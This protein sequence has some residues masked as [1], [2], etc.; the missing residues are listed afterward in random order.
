MERDP[1]RAARNRASEGFVIRQRERRAPA[2]V[3]SAVSF[4]SAVF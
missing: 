4:V 3:A 2:A 1:Y